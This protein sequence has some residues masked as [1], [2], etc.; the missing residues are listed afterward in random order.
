MVGCDK[1]QIQEYRPVEAGKLE[2]KAPIKIFIQSKSSTA[3]N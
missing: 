2:G 1:K 3:K